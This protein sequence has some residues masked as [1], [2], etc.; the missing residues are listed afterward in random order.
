[1]PRVILFLTG[2]GASDIGK[3][4][5]QT[6]AFVRGPMTCVAEAVI[7]NSL[8]N[9]SIDCWF[10]SEKELTQLVHQSKVSKRQP[11]I[12]GRSRSKKDFAGLYVRAR[13]YAT[14]VCAKAS[15]KPA[16]PVAI[17]FTDADGTH[18]SSP[19]Q[20]EQKFA[21]ILGGFEAGGCDYGVPMV[22]QPKSEAWLLAYYQKNESVS[23]SPYQNC[24]RFEKLAGND[25]AKP[26]NSAKHILERLLDGQELDYEELRQIEWQRVDMPSFNRFRDRV[27][28]VCQQYRAMNGDWQG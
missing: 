11:V 15:P 16:W 26:K 4:D 20:W 12:S 3:R 10:T 17:L 8:P 25:S 22:P 23:S 9:V 7:Q 18:S 13:V 14:E 6:D 1:M 5:F 2:E 19:H 21:A 27:C 24:A 28:D